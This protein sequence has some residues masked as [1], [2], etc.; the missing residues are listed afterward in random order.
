M[1][2]E[3]NTLYDSLRLVVVSLPAVRILAAAAR[4]QTPARMIREMQLHRSKRRVSPRT[5]RTVPYQP[6]RIIWTT[7]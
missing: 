6:L 7:M 4:M 5:K 3:C 1:R 2:G